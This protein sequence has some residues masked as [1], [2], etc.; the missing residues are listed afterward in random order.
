[1]SRKTDILA[2]LALSPLSLRRLSLGRLSFRPLSFSFLAIAAICLSI[3][4]LSPAAASE[5]AGRLATKAASFSHEEGLAKAKAESKHVVAYFWTTWCSNC[6]W[7]NESVLGDPKV[8]ESL[9]RDFVFV[10]LDADVEKELGREYMIRGVPTTIFL[11]PTGEPA[12]I[13]PGVAPPDIYANIL[14]YISSG[15]YLEMEY[16]QYADLGENAP[17]PPSRTA[18]S[19]VSSME[20]AK[21]SSK[22]DG[23]GPA[24]GASNDPS[25]IESALVLG[26]P[27]I[28][29]AASDF[30]LQTFSPALL[31]TSATVVFKLARLAKL[32]RLD[33]LGATMGEAPSAVDD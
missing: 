21:D 27:I 25:A 11:D 6:A 17:K 18:A 33:R 4:F 14:D 26:G 31:R 16:D 22:P 20:A 29:S 32:G 15:A 10:P 24:P 7:F 13:L 30:A 8:V 2:A 19:L 5:T 1:M 3:A 9:D 12:T 23:S 28:T